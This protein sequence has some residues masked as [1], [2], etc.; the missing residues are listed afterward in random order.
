MPLLPTEQQRDGMGKNSPEQ[1][2]F[3]TYGGGGR[4]QDESREGAKRD[5]FRRVLRRA[6]TAERT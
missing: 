1:L 5:E 2:I 6:G 4:A 3:E